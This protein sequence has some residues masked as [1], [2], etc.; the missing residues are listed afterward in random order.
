MI[1]LNLI[2][3]II[4]KSILFLL[5]LFI[6]KMFLFFFYFISGYQ[7]FAVVT[8]KIILRM[9]LSID[10]LLIVLSIIN[11]I[12]YIFEKELKNRIVKLLLLGL[13]FLF[14]LITFSSS[15]LILVISD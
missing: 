2:K 10:I 12:K 14:S 3:K 15:F 4:D 6:F 1:Q 11:F 13:N 8:I 7:L 5:T 9:I